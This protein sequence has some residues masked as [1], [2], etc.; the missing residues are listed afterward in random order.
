MP[1]QSFSGDSRKP[2][3]ETG[4]DRS[5]PPIIALLSDFGLT[6][7][8]VASMKG[9]ILTLCAKARLVDITHQLPAFDIRSGSYLLKTVF[10]VFPSGTIF[11]AVVDPGVGTDRPALAVRMECGRVLVGPD[12]GLLSWVLSMRKGW[13]ARSLENPEAWRPTVTPTFHGRDIFAPV[14]A[15][16]ACG[17]P[18]ESLGPLHSPMTVPW[19]RAEW[20]GRDLLGEVVHIDHFG[21][22]VTNITQRDMGGRDGLPAWKVRLPDVPALLVLC[23]TYAELPIGDAGAIIGSSGHLEIAVNRGNAARI[24][25]LGTGVPV[26][27][28]EDERGS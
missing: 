4:A 5:K 10:D 22:L 21:N 12:N 13:E 7:G 19:I 20:R 25:S 24:L 11:L 17:A 3:S 9:V 8:Y 18:F 28:S 23:R 2:S 1:R 16:I 27:V 15:H 26:I 14:A 6:D